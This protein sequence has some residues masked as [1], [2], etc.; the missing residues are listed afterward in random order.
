MYSMRAVDRSAKGFMNAFPCRPGEK[1]LA[2]YEYGAKCL[3][4]YKAKYI[5]VLVTKKFLLFCSY[6]LTV[7]K[8]F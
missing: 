6:L 7:N 8:G 1:Q 2:S 3:L 4:S 5:T